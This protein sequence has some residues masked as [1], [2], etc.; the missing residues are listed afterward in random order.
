MPPNTETNT[1]TNTGATV[2][3]PAKVEDKGDTP[4]WAG[5]LQTLDKQTWYTALPE[6]A[7]KTL[8]SGYEARLR[9]VEQGVNGKMQSW[10]T[11]K[12]DL[13]GRISKAERTAKLYETLVHGEDDPRVAEKEAEL[14][15]LKTQLQALTGE[16][17]D[18]KGKWESHSQKQVDADAQKIYEEHKAIVDNDE[19]YAEF[20]KLLRADVPVDRAAKMIHALYP[21]LVAD[22]VEVPDAVD[23]MSPGDGAHGHTDTGDAGLSLNQKVQ[24]MAE[25]VSRQLGLPS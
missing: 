11:E 22:K 6:D 2:V 12:K 21:A 20:D 25:R 3:D 15:T 13:E 1:E 19:A 4:A 10:S 23:L 17:D 24:R 14:A 9:N 18:F 8:R 16:R 5:E 7:R